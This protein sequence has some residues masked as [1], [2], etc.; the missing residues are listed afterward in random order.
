MELIPL[1][2]GSSGNCTLVRANGANILV[3][4]GKNCKA[5]KK[6]LAIVGTDPSSI[7]AVLITHSHSDHVQGLDVFIRQFPSKIYATRGTFLGMI[8]TFKKPH[9]ETPDI[10]I[11]PGEPYEVVPGVI[12]EAISTPHDASGSCCYKINDGSRSCMIATDL[13]YM[14]DD[15]MDFAKGVDAMLI[16]SNYDVRMLVYGEYPEDLKARIAGEG[17]HMSNDECAQAVKFFIDNGTRK[18]FLGHLSENNNTPGKAESTVCDY[19]A[20]QKLINGVDYEM[21]VADR[22][23][24]TEGFAF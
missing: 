21:R 22:Y 13:G 20:S 8:K 4:A 1:Y 10:I 12:I 16:E 7:D 24:P 19:L 2:S 6:A 3:D 15:I 11:N 18:F 17:G 5:I 14:T 23:A 9:D